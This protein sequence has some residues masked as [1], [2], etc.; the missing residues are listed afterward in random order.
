MQSLI[1]IAIGPSCH[2]TFTQGKDNKLNNKRGLN[3]SVT[4]KNRKTKHQ[5]YGSED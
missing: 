3:N 2:N 4:M 5:E 1:Q